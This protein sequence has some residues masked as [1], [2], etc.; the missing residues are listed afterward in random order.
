MLGTR[1]SIDR[2]SFRGVCVLYFVCVCHCLPSNL[3]ALGRLAVLQSA[4]HYGHVQ[5]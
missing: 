4:H 1:R 2:D 3:L 5:I